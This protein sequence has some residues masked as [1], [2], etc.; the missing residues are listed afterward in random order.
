MLI[1]A[2]R[3]LHVVA[4]FVALTAMWVPLVV[5][6]GNKLHRQ[7]GWMYVFAMFTA[8]LAAIAIAPLR[9]AELPS[10]A[11]GRPLFLAYVGLL[12][13]TAAF[14]GVRTCRDKARAGPSRSLADLGPP[15]LL[16]VA[17]A[18]IAGYGIASGLTLALYFAPV[19]LLVA[20]PY[21][22]DARAVSRSRLAWLIGH[23]GAMLA[24]SIATV[25][26]FLVVN[27]ARFVGP[28]GQLVAW[29]APSVVGT[30]LI[31]VFTRRYRRSAR[32]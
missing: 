2:L 15:L 3:Y 1:T 22:R 21:L 31:V 16:L 7:V 29:L 23:I 13:L 4:G 11:W 17:T 19:G 5:Q 6:K 18:A 25:T 8:A 27:A 14:R 30:G 26:A 24:S 32:S 12:S 28:E 20:V 9:M 10:E